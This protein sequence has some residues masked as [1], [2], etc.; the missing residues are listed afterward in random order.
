MGIGSLNEDH[1]RQGQD[2]Y[3]EDESFGPSL[4]A[5]QQRILQSID[6]KVSNIRSYLKTPQ[7]HQPPSRVS[8]VELKRTEVAQLLKLV[9]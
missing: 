7:R 6:A 3:H 5:C 9:S 8:A 2:G 1:V 4:V